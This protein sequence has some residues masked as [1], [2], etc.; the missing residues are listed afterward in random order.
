MYDYYITVLHYVRRLERMTVHHANT[1]LIWFSTA[2]AEVWTVVYLTGYSNYLTGYIIC[3]VTVIIWLVTVIIWLV[4]M[5][6]FCHL[7]LVWKVCSAITGFTH[8]HSESVVVSINCNL[9]TCVWL[10]HSQPNKYAKVVWQDCDC[11]RWR[12]WVHFELFQ[13][14]SVICLTT[15]HCQLLS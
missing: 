3:L 13:K 1:I 15:V 5:N 9:I 14:S 6:H 7:T 12:Q 11:K 10:F 2:L 4:S 8:L